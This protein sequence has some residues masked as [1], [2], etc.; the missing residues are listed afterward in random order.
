[1][2]KVKKAVA[3]IL[4]FALAVSCLGGCGGTGSNG[5]EGKKSNKGG[6][7]ATDIE[8]SYWNSGLGTKWL[9]AIIE[10]FTKEYPEYNVYYKAVA[11]DAA[12]VSA[13]GMEDVDTIDLYMTLQTF[14]N[15]YLE[16][17][18]S[19]LD[20]QCEDDSKTLREKFDKR[21]LDLEINR[22]GK[23]YSLTHG[24]GILGL[25]Y[26]KEL[27]KKAGITQLPRTTDEL[28]KV[29]DTLYNQDIPALTHFVNGG[30]WQFITEVWMA[31]ND[32]MDYYLNNLY[33]CMD[34][35]GNSPSK[36][37]FTKKD[38][39][40][41]ALLAYEKIVTPEYVLA[42]SNSNDHITAQTMFMN[43]AAAMMVNGSWLSNEMESAGTLDKFEMMKIPVIS[44]ITGRLNTVKTE[45]NLRK[46]I[47]AVDSVANGEKTL[48]DYEKDD[49][50]DVEG[51]SVSKED[52][53]IVYEARNSLAINY[54]GEVCMIPKYAKAKEGAMK[55]LEFFYSD[56][57][58]KIYTD[59]I[60]MIYPMNLSE[61]QLDTSSWNV[62][63]KSQ[64]T[65]QNQAVN[66]VSSV[67]ASKHSIYI[68][69]GAHPFAS[70]SF[71]DAF[72]TKNPADRLTADDIWAQIQEKVNDNYEQ[73]WLANIK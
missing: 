35:N 15:S 60:H 56:K 43:D 68:D 49:G 25:V 33:G 29:C 11:D 53:D 51:I 34:E 4:I 66:Y 72:C 41:Q 20:K 13:I 3:G 9:D 24:G 23:C 48:A 31:Q 36:E 28:A 62:F 70:V 44:S 30:Y 46:L 65:L 39:R 59:T 64:V 40:Y 10:A 22:D 26:N 42:G 5:D 47:S 38:G 71:I 2:R 27:F 50:Y 45:G 17:L 32:G 55:F 1:M 67:N 19:L 21:Y 7:S 52:W 18:D 58:Y 73:N 54:P 16:S 14:D 37:V 61:G 12:T 6:D 57:G 8:I 69:G 63:E